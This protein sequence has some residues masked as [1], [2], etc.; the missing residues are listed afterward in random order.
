MNREKWKLPVIQANENKNLLECTQAQQMLGTLVDGLLQ[1]KIKIEPV[2]CIL[3]ASTVTLRFI[4][5]VG[6]TVRRIIARSED[7]AR[8]LQVRSV[9]IISVIPKT[10]YMA[11]ECERP[12]R[13]IVYFNDLASTDEF[14]NHKSPLAIIGGVDTQGNNVFMA[15]EKF[16]HGI[17]SGQ[18]GAG[19]SV[20]IHSLIASLITRN[21]PQELK[22]ILCDVKQTELFIYDGL[23]HICTPNHKVINKAEEIPQILN[24]LTNEME[25]RYTKMLAARCQKI[26]D[27]IANG[28]TDMPRIVVII[29]E[30]ADVML[31]FKAEMEINLQRLTQKARAAGIFVL[32]ATQRPDTSV[33]TGLI[34][35]NLPSRI[36]FTVA[37]KW[38][39]L[40]AMGEVGAENLN[41]LGEALLSPTGEPVTRVQTPYID[42]E[43]VESIV[44][45]WA[46]QGIY[47]AADDFVLD[48]VEPQTDRVLVY[49]PHNNNVFYLDADKVSKWQELGIIV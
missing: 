27:Y 7:I 29:D 15:L 2:D 16:P 36:T 18:T 5:M 41:G 44:I 47:S 45:H 31:F 4:P 21:T 13:Q 22:L 3:G 38:D 32:L 43:S 39:S 46:S 24:M 14:I 30:A 35:S 48:V 11:I 42:M 49:S 25:K 1:F 8:I 20:F 33:L 12:D 34:K 19:K 40:T 23:P 17:I 6:V 9:R 10:N 26:D 28:H 37:S